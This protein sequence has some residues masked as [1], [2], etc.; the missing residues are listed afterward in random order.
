[1]DRGVP[2]GPH[3]RLLRRGATLTISCVQSNAARGPSVKGRRP[4]EP[5]GISTDVRR[6]QRGEGG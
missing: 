1:M 5:V 6:H 3:Q 2:V 4:G